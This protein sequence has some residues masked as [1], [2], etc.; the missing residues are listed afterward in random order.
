M[1]FLI[2]LGWYPTVEVLI[3]V[4]CL[5]VFVLPSLSFAI[6]SLRWLVIRVGLFGFAFSSEFRFAQ[7]Q[8]AS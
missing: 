1:G 8:Q 3:T 7:G 5:F 4:L 2:D 6:C